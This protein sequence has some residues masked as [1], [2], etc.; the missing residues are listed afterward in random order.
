MCA[1]IPISVISPLI[2]FREVNGQQVV[3]P[4]RFTLAAVIF[5][6]LAM[7]CY[8]L[9]Y[10]LTTERVEL[11]TKK[12]EKGE[13]I[14]VLLKSLFS[15]R[16]LLAVV[17]SALAMLL[18]QLLSQSM[19]VYLFT[20]YFNSAALMSVS[21]LASFLPMIVMAPIARIL[22]EK[23][24]KKECSIVG[25]AVA[26]VGYAALFIL[27]TTNP[28][29]YITLML[30]A[31]VGMGFFNMVIWAF[32]TDIIDYQEVKTGERED[33]TVYAIYSFSRKLGQALAG[34]IGGFA[35]TAIGYVSSTAGEGAV[36]QS[37]A[38]LDGIYNILTGTPVIGYLIVLVLLIFVYPLGKK[39][40]QE[41]VRILQ[42][43]RAAEQ[44]K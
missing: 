1:A 37:Q 5:G 42:E 44:G 28:W 40:V 27:H 35:L 18:C 34:G 43:R 33:G 23:F 26:V 7:V 20:D 29:V 38:T 8:M 6:V 41:N 2:L 16:A 15:N 17:G 39:Q 3:I 21:S 31:S 36:Q 14:F 11:P 13:N 10:N 30:I 19:S 4:E 32:I 24:G 9:C 25:V 12:K 22:S